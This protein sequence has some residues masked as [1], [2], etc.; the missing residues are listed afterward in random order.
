MGSEGL[1]VDIS[2]ETLTR[3]LSF[4]NMFCIRE[5]VKHRVYLRADK[6]QLGVDTPHPF[7]PHPYVPPR[8]VIMQL[9]S[10]NQELKLQTKE[11]ASKS[12][13]L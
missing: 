11:T 1:K 8:K 12:I 9:I 7:I 10:G 4:Y 5:K 2:T 3:L 13:I 6:Y